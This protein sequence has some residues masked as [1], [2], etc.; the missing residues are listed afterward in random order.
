MFKIVIISASALLIGISLSAIQLLPSL[1]LSQHITRASGTSYEFATS[2]SFEIQN[3]ITFVS[4]NFFGFENTYW[5][6]WYYWELSVYI[7]ILTLILILFAVYFRRKNRYVLFF[8]GL[9]FLSLL[10]ALGAN[11]PLYW[12]LWKFC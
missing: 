12:L 8:A 7:G 5:N 10:L 3:F 9:A 6:V 1:E 11:T 2:H 4:P